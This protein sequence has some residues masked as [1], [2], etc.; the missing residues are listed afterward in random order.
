MKAV[1]VSLKRDQRILLTIILVVV[2]SLWAYSTVIFRP[3]SQQLHRVGQDVRTASLKLQL[4][5]QVVAQEPQLR[6]E[7]SQLTDTLQALRTML[8]SEEELPSVIGLLSDLASQT[9]VKIQTIFPQRSLE[10]SG[11]ASGSQAAATKPPEL[12]KEIPVQIDALAGFHQLGVF[13]SRVESGTQPMQLKSL[14][15]SGN[16]KEPRRHSVK[17]V[18]LVYFSSPEAAATSRSATYSGGATTWLYATA[19]S[20]SFDSLRSLRTTLSKGP[21]P[22]AVARVEGSKGQGGT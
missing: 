6:Q 2:M 9:G 17:L 19:S 3:L 22:E 12:Y 18:L 13:L 16:P 11:A 5:E 4:M 1:G 8:P 15:I 10:G 21:R 7:L 14:R 20:S